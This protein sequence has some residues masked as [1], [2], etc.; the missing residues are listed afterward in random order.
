MK[1]IS[2][3]YFNSLRPL[4]DEAQV[5]TNEDKELEAKGFDPIA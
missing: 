2:L 4:Q 1:A 3:K 5:V